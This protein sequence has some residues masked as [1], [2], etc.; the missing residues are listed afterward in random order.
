MKYLDLAP[1]LAKFHTL[2]AQWALVL[3]FSLSSIYPLAY[4]CRYTL[5][6]FLI[7]GEDKHRLAAC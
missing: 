3:P 4:I 5:N 1:F 2:A 6:I 7:N